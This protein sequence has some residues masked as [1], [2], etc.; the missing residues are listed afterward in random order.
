[1]ARQAPPGRGLLVAGAGVLIASVA[2]AGRQSSEPV[3]VV[4]S[5][6]GGIASGSLGN[7]RNDPTVTGYLRC[8]V[9]HEE[10]YVGSVPTGEYV[11]TGRCEAHDGENRPGRCTTSN[12]SLID[13]IRGI[14]SLTKVT[15]TWDEAGTCTAIGIE[16][17]SEHEPPDEP[18]SPDCSV[19]AGGPR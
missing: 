14:D 16:Q 9:S 7:A 19:A 13:Q 18:R 6:S 2:L 10:T 8:S 15:F 12:P 11:T 1:M 17:S 5:S 3:A 4:W